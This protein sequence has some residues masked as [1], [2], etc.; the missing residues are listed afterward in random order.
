MT[1]AGGDANGIWDVGGDELEGNTRDHPHA[2]II[3]PVRHVHSAQKR[4]LR[5]L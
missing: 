3:R 2:S 1:L 4:C 5:S